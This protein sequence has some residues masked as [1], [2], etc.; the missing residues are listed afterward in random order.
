MRLRLE[1]NRV[2]RNGLRPRGLDGPA[3]GRGLV[4]R[5]Q[6]AAGSVEEIS[7]QENGHGVPWAC[8]SSNSL[9]KEGER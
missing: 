4:I 3:S 6:L 9:C 8:D 1:R 5:E 2:L 7:H